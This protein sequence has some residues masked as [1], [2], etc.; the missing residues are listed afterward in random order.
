MFDSRGRYLATHGGTGRR[1]PRPRFGSNPARA[2]ALSQHM[3]VRER[4][5]L[6]KGFPGAD[7][8]EALP[9][10]GFRLRASSKA[11]SASVVT[12]VRC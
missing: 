2:T 10:P 6:F 1:Q 7:S 4:L 8:R 11:A 3:R 9:I 5:T 12:G